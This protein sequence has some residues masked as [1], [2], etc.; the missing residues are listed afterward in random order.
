M[1][2]YINNTYN[3]YI[4]IHTLLSGQPQRTALP[5]LQECPSH[6]LL[7]PLEAYLLVVNIQ[8][9]QVVCIYIYTKS[10]Y[11]NIGKTSWMISMLVVG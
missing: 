9:Q 2:I 5:E 10:D 1:Y 4:Y 8:K 6:G 11:L 3:I 7:R